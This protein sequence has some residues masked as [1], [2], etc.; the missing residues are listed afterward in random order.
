MRKRVKQAFAGAAVTATAVLAL[1]V[2]AASADPTLRIGLS[3]DPDMLDPTMGRTFVGRIVFAGLCDKL[4]DMRPDLQIVPMLATS[5]QWSEDG[6]ALTLKLRQGVTFHDGEPFDAAA[7]KF[8]VERHL[9]LPGSN[10]KGEIAA[11]S[12]VDVLDGTTV[13][14]NL[15]SVFAP[16]LA[17]LT[18]RAG[19]M[20]SPKAAQ[21]AGA[22]FARSPVCSGPFKFVER[23]PQDRIVLEKFQGYW[24]KDKIHFDKVVYLPIVD[25][26]VRLANL[27]SGGIDLIERMLPHDVATVQGDKR[28]KTASIVELGY[29][30]IT[31]NTNNGPKAQ[32]ALGGPDPRVREAFELTIDRDALNQVVF[33]GQFVPGNQWVSPQS[34]YYV[35]SL[36]IPKRDVARAKQLLKEAG[37]PNPVIDFMVPNDSERLQVAQVIQAMAAEAGFDLRIRATEFA[38]SLDL[39][40]RGEFEAYLLAWSGRL[41]PDGN[42]FI[43]LGCKGPFNYGKYCKPEVD[44]EIMAGRSV[45]APE[46]R[47][48]HYTT[49]A[50]AVLRDRPAIYLFH[51]RWLYGHTAK[52]DGFQPYPDGLIRLVGMRMP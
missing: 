34:P 20:V 18:D 5:Y 9:N 35:K 21:A 31:I 2:G 22:D 14:L 45:L 40:E 43:A 41:D 25:G 15:S 19:M 13:R 8:N 38:T 30:G 36:P 44:A 27:Q 51:R 33:E 37:K 11:I 42:L 10:R 48:K 49:V 12:G 23:V 26:S 52:L 16:L 47:M 32:G 46:E 24:N 50:Q 29:Q 17:Q 1:G 3:E 28:L 7:V 4:L 39:G 6:K